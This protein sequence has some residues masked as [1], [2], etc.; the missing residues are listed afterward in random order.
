MTDAML[1][2]ME[3]RHF[4]FNFLPTHFPW[5]QQKA[6]VEYGPGRR[7]DRTE[8]AWSSKA[9]LTRMASQA[10]VKHLEHP[11]E[12]AT[13]IIQVY[14]YLFMIG[15]KILFLDYFLTQIYLL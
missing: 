3:L 7:D 5:R 10:R 9:Q 1:K 14:L 6:F 8:L 15:G 12:L 13:K 2:G 11:L 4:T